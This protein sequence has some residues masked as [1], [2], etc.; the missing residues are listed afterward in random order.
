[1]AFCES[2]LLAC[3][4]KK[5]ISVSHYPVRELGRAPDLQEADSLLARC[6]G[7]ADKVVDGVLGRF[8]G[9]GCKGALLSQVR[10]SQS[11]AKHGVE[12]SKSRSVRRE[13]RE[14]AIA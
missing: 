6:A 9:H 11:M 12:E 3:D 2:R 4:K 5:Y 13:W 14:W 7:E 1:M 8:R 10:K